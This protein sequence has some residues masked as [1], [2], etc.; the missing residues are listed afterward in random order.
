MKAEEKNAL[1][2]V[3]GLGVTAWILYAVNSKSAPAHVST[4]GM[5]QNPERGEEWQVVMR[6]DP[7]DWTPGDEAVLRK[8]YADTAML[9]AATLRGDMLTLTLDYIVNSK[10]PPVGSSIPWGKGTATLLG[11]SFIRYAPV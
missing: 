4:G 6:L 3:A 1:G 11:A 5:P 9:Q 2:L 10:F 7:P 8:E